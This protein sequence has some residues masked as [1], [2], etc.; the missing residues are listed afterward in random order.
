MISSSGPKVS[1]SLFTTHITKPLTFLIDSMVG[2]GECRLPYLPRASKYRVFR[3][4]NSTGIRG[5]M[6]LITRAIYPIGSRM[7]EGPSKVNL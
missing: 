3:E 1:S 4:M 6:A 2:R 5:A 7:T